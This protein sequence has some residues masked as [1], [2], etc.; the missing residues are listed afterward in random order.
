MTSPYRAGEP[1]PD[2]YALAG[3]KGLCAYPHPSTD[4]ASIRAHCDRW[5][6]QYE[7][8]VEWARLH[9]PYRV[10]RYALGGSDG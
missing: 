10:V 1:L 8:G 7:T 4:E 9:G 2:L 6:G 5:N 3:R